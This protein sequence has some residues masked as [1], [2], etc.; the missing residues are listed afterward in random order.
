M[1]NVLG[2]LRFG[3]TL[4]EEERDIHDK[5]LAAVLKQLHDDLDA[6][7]FAAYGWSS[8]LTDREIL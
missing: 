7:V 4:T 5:G 8:A 2:K 3:E 1:Y 6:A